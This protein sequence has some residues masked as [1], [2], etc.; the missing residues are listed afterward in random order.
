MIVAVLP[1]E[2]V[3]READLL[4]DAEVLVAHVLDLDGDVAPGPLEGEGGGV[5]VVVDGVDV[6]CHGL[7]LLLA[8]FEL[9]QGP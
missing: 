5:T 8:R 4:L 1:I 6:L 7:E 9:G 3:R 2:V